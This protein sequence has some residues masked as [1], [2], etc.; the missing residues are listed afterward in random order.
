MCHKNFYWHNKTTLTIASA[1]LP[2]FIECWKVTLQIIII[3]FHHVLNETSIIFRKIIFFSKTYKL[4]TLRAIVEE[5]CEALNINK[6]LCKNLVN[7]K[8]H[9]KKCI[10]VNGKHYEKLL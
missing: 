3:M 4:G 10:E 9:S 2:I 6:D 5:E 8:Q 7:V 1:Y